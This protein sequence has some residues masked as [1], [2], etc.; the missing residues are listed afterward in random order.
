MTTGPDKKP[1][2]PDDYRLVLAGRVTGGQAFLVLVLSAGSAGI[3]AAGGVANQP[4]LFVPVFALSVF[5]AVLGRRSVTADAPKKGPLWSL[6][7]DVQ[8]EGRSHLS[9][10]ISA[11]AAGLRMA[12]TNIRAD[13][14]APDATGHIL[15]M[16]T[17]LQIRMTDAEKTLRIPEGFGVAGAC[18][19]RGTPVVAAGSALRGGLVQ[20]N[21]DLLVTPFWVGEKESAKLDPNLSWIIGAPICDPD[22]RVIGVCIVDGVA[23]P[24]GT[25]SV[26]DQL[27]SVQHVVVDAAAQIA[28]L[29]LE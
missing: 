17:D 24:T 2:G 12:E 10:A 28:Q 26:E 7:K 13:V 4:W 9:G 19:Q 23:D 11:V 18:F 15:R 3:T 5:V 20:S 1:T 27:R 6:P 25:G 16:V 29:L 14:F 21:G 22:D 8:A